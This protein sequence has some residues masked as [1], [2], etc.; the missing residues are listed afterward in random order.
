[1]YS[2]SATDVSNECNEMHLL[3]MIKLCLFFHSQVR[4]EHCCCRDDDLNRIQKQIEQKKFEKSTQISNHFYRF[5]EF[6]NY[7]CFLFL[8]DCKNVTHNIQLMIGVIK[9]L[10]VISRP[11]HCD[12]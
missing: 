6:H 10:L 11:F 4:D 5:I 12:T 9:I 7:S 3:T 8:D 2:L 1:M